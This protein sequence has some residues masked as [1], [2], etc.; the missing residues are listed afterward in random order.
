MLSI[1]IGLYVVVRVCEVCFVGLA[2]FYSGQLID[3]Y[4]KAKFLFYGLEYFG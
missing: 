2:F 3:V 4:H 1:T